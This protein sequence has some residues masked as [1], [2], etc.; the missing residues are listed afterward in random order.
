MGVSVLSSTT[1]GGRIGSWAA[2]LCFGWDSDAL[3]SIFTL[4]HHV[5]GKLSLPM[6]M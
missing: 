6:S 5:D 3:E 4:C 2:S 1:G